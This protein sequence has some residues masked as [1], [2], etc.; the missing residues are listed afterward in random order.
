MDYTLKESKSFNNATVN[1]ALT[2][3]SLAVKGLEGKVTKET[4]QSGEITAWF[5]KTIHGKVLGDRT[6]ME[7]AVTEIEPGTIRVD[8]QS[9]PLDAVGRKM[10]FGARAGVNK[11][12]LTWFMA[13]LDHQ[14]EKLSCK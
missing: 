10:M 3:V 12:V 6:Q 11:T 8:V 9:Y 5:N 7:I 14:M 2:A 1:Q 13:H 4:P